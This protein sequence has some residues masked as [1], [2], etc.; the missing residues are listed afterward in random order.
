[1][2]ATPAQCPVCASPRI[3]KR[4]F[5][6]RVRVDAE[7]ANWVAEV[8]WHEKQKIERMK[9][10][11]IELELPAATL[12]EA[13][14]FI[15]SFGKHALALAPETVVADVREHVTALARAYAGA[16]A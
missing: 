8:H 12:L 4:P 5:R 15:L 3:G 10:G 9:D 14:R 1:M 16:H 7:I 6:F 11:S 13:R 2:S